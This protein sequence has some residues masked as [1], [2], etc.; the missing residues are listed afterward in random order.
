MRA[1]RAAPPPPRHP[2]LRPAR[3]HRGANPPRRPV[4][5][6]RPKARNLCTVSAPSPQGAAP[7]SQSPA[8]SVALIPTR[9]RR[10]VPRRTLPACAQATG[11]FPPAQ[12]L[13]S[14]LPD[15]RTRHPHRETRP[16]RTRLSVSQIPTPP[17]H[18]HRPVPKC[19]AATSLPRGNPHRN[20]HAPIPCPNTHPI[21][22]QPNTRT[23]SGGGF[24][25][26]GKRQGIPPQPSHIRRI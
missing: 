9:P 19:A 22:P 14:R 10:P 6:A 16:H 25:P 20:R 24:R 3:L 2:A 12:G 23:P 15:A 4:R 17:R 5:T 26:A 7:F 13:P 11:S 18:P 21:P 8:L 1:P